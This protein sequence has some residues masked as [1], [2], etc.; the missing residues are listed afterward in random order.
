MRERELKREGGGEEL[1]V[2]GR[3]EGKREG[4]MEERIVSQYSLRTR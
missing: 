4:A 3:E 2:E 1:E